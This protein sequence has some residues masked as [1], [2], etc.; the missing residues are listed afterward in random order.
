LA[1]INFIT[2]HD[3]LTLHDLVSYNQKHNEANGED[4]RDGDDHNRS[5]NC[6]VEGPTSDPH[7]LQL[8]EQQM[9]NLFTT[10]LMSQGVPMIRAGDETGHSQL[11]NNNA[12]CQDNEISWLSWQLNAPARQRL[13]FVQRLVRLRE[14]LIRHRFFVR[15]VWDLSSAPADVRWIRQNGIP[16]SEADWHDGQTQVGVLLT[17]RE[18][19]ALAAHDEVSG[20]DVFLVFN[21]HHEPLVVRLPVPPERHLWRVTL[22][23]SDPRR[24]SARCKSGQYVVAPRSSCIFVSAPAGFLARRLLLRNREQAGFR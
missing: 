6:G 15:F 17:R 16:M 9:R 2:C 3:G 4:N 13:K 19:A 5:W 10:L 7:V 12:Y 1:S 24:R 11:G 23:T 20:H 8:R 21:A 22:D 18:T 14:R